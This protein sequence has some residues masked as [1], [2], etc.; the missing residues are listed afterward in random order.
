[1]AFG[2]EGIITR[3][4]NIDFRRKRLVVHLEVVRL[5]VKDTPENAPAVVTKETRW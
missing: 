5:A 4:V 3:P 1:M 2:K